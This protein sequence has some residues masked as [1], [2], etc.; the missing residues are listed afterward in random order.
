MDLEVEEVEEKSENARCAHMYNC[1]S[2]ALDALDGGMKFW[3]EMR[4]LEL[5]PK[6]SD[7]FMPDKLNALIYSN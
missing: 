1:I 2:D 4:N 3:R 7:D 5:T 6:A